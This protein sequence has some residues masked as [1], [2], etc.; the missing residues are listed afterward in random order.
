MAILRAAV[1]LTVSARHLGNTIILT[2]AGRIVAGPEVRYLDQ[3]VTELIPESRSIVLQLSKVV[4][5]DSSGMGTLVRL[6][7]RLKSEGINL[8]L[9]GISSQVQK[10]LEI[11]N[12]LKL[13][14]VYASEEE[15]AK[16]AHDSPGDHA[17]PTSAECVLCIG[18]TSDIRV[19]LGAL[20]RAAGYQ[21]LTCGGLYDAK[22]LLRAGKPKLIIV[23]SHLF[24]DVPDLVRELK[25]MDSSLPIL[26]L[27]ENF[28][29]QE[30]S[31]AGDKLVTRIRELL[32]GS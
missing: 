11:T 20:V 1:E 18:D 4:F 9:C 19:Y 29:T 31:D 26:T 27:D 32:H 6:L 22:I 12:L 14:A 5:L 16:A 15:A 8:G 2:C 17:L 13:F 24:S 3:Q 30:A 10:A 21:P 28:S 25:G 23:G 7:T